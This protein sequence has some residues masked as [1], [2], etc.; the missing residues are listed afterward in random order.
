MRDLSLDEVKIALVVQQLVFDHVVHR[1][2]VVGIGGD[3]GVAVHVVRGVE[4]V[5]E[6]RKDACD[7]S[8]S[9]RC[10]ADNS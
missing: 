3:D 7:Q 5:L 1:Y 4:Q 8:G 6:I 9:Y 2:G 10:Q